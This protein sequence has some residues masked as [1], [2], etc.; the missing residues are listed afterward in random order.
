MSMAGSSGTVTSNPSSK[1]IRFVLAPGLARFCGRHSRGS[2]ASSSA[3]PWRGFTAGADHAGGSRPVQ[4]ACNSNWTGNRSGLSRLPN[5]SDSSCPPPSVKRCRCWSSEGK[6]DE[7]CGLAVDEVLSE[8]D[9][10][11]PLDPRLPRHGC[12]AIA[13]AAIRADGAA[14]VIDTDDLLRTGSNSF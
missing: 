8:E 14:F 7:L 1:G 3:C 2:A 5:C 13:S 9:L 11:R 6:H 12:L 10:V 4:A